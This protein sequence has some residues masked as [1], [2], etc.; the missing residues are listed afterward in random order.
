MSQ[1]HPIEI[2]YRGKSYRGEWYVEGV[3]LHVVCE[4]GSKS[5]AVAVMSNSISMP[6]ELAAELFWQ[7]MREKDPK[8][9]F[10]YWR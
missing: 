3:L 8:R 7:L 2:T 4:H 9:P 6:S 1:R 10:L 5:G